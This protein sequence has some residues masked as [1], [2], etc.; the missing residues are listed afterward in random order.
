ML[1]DQIAMNKRRTG[2]VMFGFGVLTLA[3]GASIG[4]PLL[5]QLGVR[6][7]DCRSGGGGLHVDY[8]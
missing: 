7:R 8:D 1:Y 4:L 3:I 6:N 2:Y 5:E